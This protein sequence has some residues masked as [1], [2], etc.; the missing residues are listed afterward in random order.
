M[1]TRF[2]Q[3]PILSLLYVAL[4]KV[5]LVR[6]ELMIHPQRKDYNIFWEIT[7][8]APSICTMNHPDFIV[9]SFMESSIGQKRVNDPSTENGLQYF[10]GNYNL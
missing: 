3:W 9:C 4:W 10:L 5:P 2:I 7:T 1:T 6:K 8:S